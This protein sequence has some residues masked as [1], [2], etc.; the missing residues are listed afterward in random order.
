MATRP[1][2][3]SS[4]Y[5]LKIWASGP[6]SRLLTTSAAVSPSSD[7]RISSGPSR[8]KEKPRSAWSSCIED[9]PMSNTTPSSLVS[10]L[11]ANASARPENGVRISRN[12]PG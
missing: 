3:R 10:P 12:L 11:S 4:P 9:T 1:D 7:I 8:M 5:S 6:W 2:W